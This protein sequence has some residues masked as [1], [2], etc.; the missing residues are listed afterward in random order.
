MYAFEVVEIRSRSGISVCWNFMGRSLNSETKSSSSSSNTQL[1]CACFFLLVLLFLLSGGAGVEFLDN[2]GVGEGG[3]AFCF[4]YLGLVSGGIKAVGFDGFGRETLKQT[5]TKRN[6]R[7]VSRS[8]L[9]Q[10]RYK[11]GAIWFLL[12][13][14]KGQRLGLRRT[15]KVMNL[16]KE[17][18]GTRS[19]MS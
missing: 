12:Q 6:K 2:L 19:G 15:R 13:D 9:L 11:S 5:E 3:F 17:K 4:G 14:L 18:E 8:T 10:P 16:G 7:R 1:G